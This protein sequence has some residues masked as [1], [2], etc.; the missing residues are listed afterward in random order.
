MHCLNGKLVIVDPISK[1]QFKFILSF[2]GFI[3]SA[4]KF[5]SETKFYSGSQREIWVNFFFKETSSF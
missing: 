4:Y 3:I 2:G 5:I 1:D